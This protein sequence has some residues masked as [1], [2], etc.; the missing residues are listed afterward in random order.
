MGRHDFVPVTV[1]FVMFF[2]QT[3]QFLTLQNPPVQ[4]PVGFRNTYRERRIAEMS[5]FGLHENKETSARLGYRELH[6]RNHNVV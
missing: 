3:D 5:I 1:L 2:S 4:V 6:N